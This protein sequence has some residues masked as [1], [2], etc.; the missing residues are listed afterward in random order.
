[1]ASDNLSDID[2]PYRVEDVVLMSPGRWNN[3]Q[4][5]EETLEEA[6][7]RT[8]WDE[9]HNSSVFWEH[10]D[11]DA[12]DWIGEVRNVRFED[13]AVKGDIDFVDE[14]AARKLEYGAHFGISPKVSGARK[15]RKMQRFT[16]DNF[17]LVIDPAVKT[18]YLNS[19]THFEVQKMSDD[20]KVE[21]I[22]FDDLKEEVQE[23]D[24]VD[25]EDVLGLAEETLQESSV[26]HDLLF[27]FLS[28]VLD[29]PAS[30]VESAIKG[31]MGEEEEKEGGMSEHEGEADGED[32]EDEMS[33]EQTEDDD[34]TL[35]DDFVKF[36]QEMREDNPDMAVDEIVAEYK[37]AQKTPEERI[38][39]LR[40]ELETELMSEV[41]DELDSLKKEL[42]ESTEEMRDEI[43]QSPKR[44]S[45]REGRK[46]QVEELSELDPR[47][48]DR[49]LLETLRSQTSGNRVN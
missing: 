9:A 14:D 29:I 46:E 16:Y 42:K 28:E 6:V 5:P 31:A 10:D 2:V 19:D 36:A 37:D 48:K 26:D 33:D 18:T 24:D 30:N 32:G 27:G 40:E 7:E 17:S 12:R 3:I 47:D 25:A 22:G 34:V 8:D 13:G 15:G 45:V 44:A 35:D 21:S 23:M 38:D 1:M 43:Q 4:Y 41:K 20:G 49:K 11:E 39:E